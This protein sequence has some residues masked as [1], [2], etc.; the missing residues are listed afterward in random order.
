MRTSLHATFLAHVVVSVCLAKCFAAPSPQGPA[1]DN[2]D[3][4]IV[5][6]QDHAFGIVA[7]SGWV[8][9]NSSGVRVGLHAVFYPKGSSWKASPVVM[10]AN[11]VHKGTT[12]TRPMKAIIAE[13]VAAFEKKAKT[14]AVSDGPALDTKNRKKDAVVK[15][16][17]D[18]ARNVY[19][20][21]AYIDEPAVVVMFV[22]S[23]DSKESVEAAMPAFK[24]LVGSC[25]FI[26]SQVT[27]K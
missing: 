11:T 25:F 9:D 27:E 6:G 1:Q 2:M 5:Y 18:A 12:E 13:D 7:P 22:L 4:G 15:R 17:A 21:V 3:G 23:A 14:P 24:E 26:T 20:V 8:L 10:Y 16:F 19:E